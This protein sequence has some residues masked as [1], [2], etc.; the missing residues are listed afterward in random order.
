MSTAYEC[1]ISFEHKTYDFSTVTWNQC[2]MPDRGWATSNCGLCDPATEKQVP[3]ARKKALGMTKVKIDH[4]PGPRS[5]YANA[6][7]IKRIEALCRCL[8]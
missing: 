3:R 6:G 5:N 7:V 8:I 2:G 1:E 4:Y